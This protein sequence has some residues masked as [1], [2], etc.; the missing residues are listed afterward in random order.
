MAGIG[1]ELNKI[2]QKGT[3][4]SIL[5]VFLLGTIIV[6]G[7]W[8][9]SILSIY[10]IQKYAY[11]AISEDPTL[12]TVSIVY[13][14]AF[15]LIIFG[16]IHYLFS[17]YIADMMYIENREA[18]PSALLTVFTIILI[19]SIA[20]SSIF[21]SL[22]SFSILSYPRLY[23][24]SLIILFIVTNLIW[25][26]LIYV[27]LLKEYYKI[28]V[29]YLL[30]VVVSVV[31]VLYFGK[32]YGVAGALLGY[33]LGQAVIVILLLIIAQRSYPLKRFNLNTQIFIYFKE[34]RYLFLIGIFF[35]FG[36]WIDK[37]FYWYILGENIEGT[38]FFYYSNY[39]IP[40]FL[41]Y[42]TMIPGLVYFLVVSEPIFHTAYT[43]FIKNILEDNITTIYRKKN[44]M[45]RSLK[46]GVSQLL[47]FQGVWTIGLVMNT[48][49]FLSFM[50]YQ[51][52]DS[53]ITGILIIAVFFHMTALTFQIYLLYLELRKEAL[54]STIVYFAVN[55]VL[56]LVLILSHLDL[57]GIS[58]MI[59]ALFSSLYS[60]NHI[61]RKIP[62]IDY[63]IFN[64]T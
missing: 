51:Y 62:I 6:A 47:L 24:Y 30:G 21:I 34:F 41:A 20:I 23:K 19:L 25:I 32:Q 28:F 50:G 52:I 9:L 10:V 8:I 61:V 64:K 12:F 3:L 59:A 29:S 58:Y 11:M 48:E 35:N 13:V 33:S 26:M 45:I 14:Y 15:S 60:I 4:G 42:I 46:N 56:T 57:P 44:N 54:I 43:E 5:K 16:G 37:I 39:D 27:A 36:I 40:V 53:T 18:I 38:L 2:L 49:N 17:R 63:I 31:G 7:P 22:N 1:F 55:T